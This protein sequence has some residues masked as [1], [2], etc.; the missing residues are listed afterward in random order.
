MNR[1]LAF[2]ALFALVLGPLGQAAGAAKTVT[3]STASKTTTTT[4]V[5]KGDAIAKAKAFF[6]RYVQLE[7]A[8]DPALAGLYADNAVLINKRIYPDGKVNPVRIPASTYKHL[9]QTSIADPKQRGNINTYSNESY[10]VEGDKVRIKATAYRVLK[11]YSSPLSQL[12]G[13]DAKG[14]WVIY[15]E[16]SESHM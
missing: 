7:H 14:N 4:T 10:T 13:P 8:Y 1:T 11:K 2:A 15:E 12:V 9:I 6:A 5:S 3:K 16:T